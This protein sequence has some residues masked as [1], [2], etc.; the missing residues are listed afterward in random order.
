MKNLKKTRVKLPSGE[1]VIGQSVPDSLLNQ[2]R[3]KKLGKVKSRTSKK[4]KK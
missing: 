1:K 2:E 4:R 3:L